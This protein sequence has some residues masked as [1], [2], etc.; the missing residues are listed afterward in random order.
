MHPS[1]SVRHVQAGG[2]VSTVAGGGTS[3]GSRNIRLREHRKL[4]E[5]L[6]AIRDGR[7]VVELVGDPG[8]GKTRLLTQLAAEARS[9]GL[10]VAQG[11]ATEGDQ[12]VMLKSI[13]ASLDC[14]LVL[15]ASRDLPN[16]AAATIRAIWSQSP[17][18]FGE[19]FGGDG[20][21]E[22]V[23]GVA[24]REPRDLVLS[25][26]RGLLERLAGNSPTVVILDDSHWADPYTTDL[27]DQLVRYPLNA[28]LL[29]VLAHRPRQTGSTLRSTLAQGVVSGV[30]E[31]IQLNELTLGQAADLLSVEARS[32]RSVDLHRESQ[33]VP[34]YLLALANPGDNDEFVQL[35][36]TEAAL[37]GDDER[38]VLEAAAVID[39]CFDVTALASVAGLERARVCV[40]ATRL[41]NRDLFRHA[42]PASVMVL[43]HP[44]V[45]DAVYAAT[46]GCWRR[47]AHRRAIDYLRDCGAPPSELAHH[48]A[49]AP[50][51]SDSDDLDILLR[52]AEEPLPGN[53]ERAITWLEAALR[54]SLPRR[55]RGLALIALSRALC[56]AERFADAMPH[57]R[58]AVAMGAALPVE[59]W[60]KA[61][62]QSAAIDTL[63]GRYSEANATLDGALA[64]LR[65]RPSLEEVELLVRRGVIGLYD[66]GALDTGTVDLAARRAQEFACHTSTAAA[67]ALR[68]L[69]STSLGDIETALDALETSASCIEKLSDAELARS[70]D[71][72][73]LLGWAQLN[74]ARLVDAEATMRRGVTLAKE[75]GATTALPL[76]LLGLSLVNNVMGRIGES[77]RAAIEAKEWGRRVGAEQVRDFGLALEANCAIWL[78]RRNDSKRAVSRAQRLIKALPPRTYWYSMG[79]LMCLAAAVEMG[80][81][82]EYCIALVLDAGGGGALPNFV[83]PLRAQCF[84]LLCAA[85]I[86]QGSPWAGEY[87]ERSAAAAEMLGLTYQ[88]AFAL[89]ARGHAHRASGRVEE[90]AHHYREAADL[91]AVHGA[92]GSQA[93]ALTLA[94]QCVSAAGSPGRAAEMLRPAKELALRCGSPLLLADVGA[95]ENSVAHAVREQTPAL[96]PA[97]VPPTDGLDLSCLTDR[98]REIAQIAGRGCRTKEIAEQLFVSPR[99]VEVHLSRVY[100]KLNI[101]SR[102]VLV[103]LLTRAAA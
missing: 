4:V 52:A 67:M 103:R 81:C 68:A 14:R 39:G 57:L 34:Q 6:G 79:A 86:H 89:A 16:D 17:V 26:M 60:A 78:S 12:R 61:V 21:H 7:R 45:R 54:L 94:A 42:T 92:L 87:A 18:R 77:R 19:A 43:R 98:E 36:Q 25:A 44:L 22:S 38:R 46:D 24:G 82:S 59:I 71:C 30:V 83:P 95:E 27:I 5:A 15:A 35:V 29:I 49:A 41:L 9:R 84:E 51:S 102:A 31:R 50:D 56:V 28:P 101:P 73:A 64:M 2:L 37:L 90:A 47:E 88:Q 53:P 11:R 66:G 10:V 93:R 97:N 99:T 76:F 13:T 70:P 55:Q 100:R 8:T 20:D 72:L 3:S 23:P 48:V 96:P 33:G 1:N 80:E 32:R 63:F 91:F 69:K 74:A 58:E 65:G 62:S 40:A 85:A 75:F